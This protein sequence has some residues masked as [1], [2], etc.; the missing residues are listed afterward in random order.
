MGGDNPGGKRLSVNLTDEKVAYPNQSKNGVTLMSV[1]PAAQAQVLQKS[2]AEIGDVDNFVMQQLGYSSKDELYSKLAAEQ[3]DSVALAINQMNNG[4]AFII[5]DMTGV[6]K[7][8]QG[9]AL[10]RYAVRQGK[11]PVYFT[12]IPAL[13][14]DNYR[15]LADIGSDNLRPFIMASSKEGEIVAGKGA[16]RKVIYKLPSAKEVDRVF[17]FINEHGKLPDEYDY[18]LATYSQIQNGTKDYESSENG[19]HPID[20]KL[21]KNSKGY[22]AADRNAQMRRD[23]LL[24]IAGD[25]YVILDESHTVGG[26]G[27]GAKFMQALTG[28]ANGVTFLS[29]TFAKRADNMP[30]YAQRTAISDCDISQDELIG[31]IAK[32][33]VTLQEIMSKQLVE[34]GQMIRRERSFEGVNIDWLSV[35]EE[36]DKRQREQFDEVATIFNDIRSVFP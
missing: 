26:Q 25:S 17:K 3:I 35:D 29:A 34:S 15:D 1:V 22:T 30:I 36:T 27:G 12:K 19:W 23:A 13:Y 14:S 5:G 18:I 33:G 11:V 20:K 10:I 16:D 32:G 2:L 7:G 31:A 21:K 28:S 9:A 24:S 6:G 4:N 8:R